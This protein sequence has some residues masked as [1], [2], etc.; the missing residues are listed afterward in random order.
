[1]R[2]PSKLIRPRTND[3]DESWPVKV[4]EGGYGCIGTL[5]FYYGA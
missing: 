2:Y 5:A 1:M 4:E 3:L